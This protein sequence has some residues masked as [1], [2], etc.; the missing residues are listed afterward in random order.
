MKSLEYVIN[1]YVS[2]CIDG[3]D[4][5]R[6]G[7]FVPEEDLKRLALTANSESTAQHTPLNWTRRVYLRYA[8]V[9]P[10]GC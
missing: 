3:R 2:T 10:D 4:V 8:H 5:V 9:F 1:T 7:A 6:L